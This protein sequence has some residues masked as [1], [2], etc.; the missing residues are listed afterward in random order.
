[1]WYQEEAYK[2]EGVDGRRNHG[3]FSSFGVSTLIAGGCEVST[4]EA[5]R[6]SVER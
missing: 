1:M 4:E 6:D 3:A 2:E 5:G